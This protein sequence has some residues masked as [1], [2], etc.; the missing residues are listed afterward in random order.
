M[1]RNLSL[2]D[3]DGEIWK[4]IK[5]Y[6][7]SY[8]VSNYGR[9]KSVF[10]TIT[11]KTGKVKSHK[12]RILRQHF[13]TTGYLNADLFDKTF[14]VH[15]LVGEAF[16]PLN[17]AEQNFINHKDFN[18]LNNRVENLEWCTPKENV[19]H[20]VAHQRNKS[21]YY[22]DKNEIIELYK[23]GYTSIEIAKRLGITR[24]VVTNLVKKAGISRKV[25]L[26]KSK[27]IS[28][29]DLKKLFEQGLSNKEIAKRYN[30]PSNYIARRR[31]QIRKG[32]I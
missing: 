23:Q 20:A 6:E 17:N 19:L 4:P 16:I 31:Y 14:K 1:Y 21:Y 26:Q 30:I 32:E 7:G 29:A 12:P 28:I 10:T 25:Y 13:S 18:R 5:G 3:I 9:V 11:E 8:E 2:D 24:A 27:Y 15:R 22:A